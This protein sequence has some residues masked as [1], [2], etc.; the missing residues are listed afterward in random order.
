M[1]ISVVKEDNRYTVE[2]QG[3]FTS[4]FCVTYHEKLE[5]WDQKCYLKPVSWRY[6]RS[7]ARFFVDIQRKTC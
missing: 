5:M 6:I 1:A 7:M 3:H 4:W 2:W